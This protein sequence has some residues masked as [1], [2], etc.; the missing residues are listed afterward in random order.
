[1]RCNR[2][3]AYQ[4]MHEGAIALAEVQ[5]NGIRVDMAYLKEK[6]KST[7][8]QIKKIKAV[9]EECKE[10]RKWKKL[11]G[12][13]FNLDSND[14]LADILY[15]HLGYE[16]V[17]ETASGNA[18][19]DKKA[20]ERIDLPM[21]KQLLLLRKLQKARGTY[22]AGISRE[23]VDG[24]LYPFFNLHTVKTYR[25]S[26]NNPNFQ[27]MPI[28][29]PFMGELI[30]RAFI[31]RENRILLELD[32]SSIEVKIAACYHKDPTMLSYIKDPSKDMHRDMAAQCYK[33]P[34]EQVTKFIRYCGKNMYVFPEFYGSY[35]A[36][37]APDLWSAAQKEDN[38]LVDGTLLKEHLVAQGLG[39]YSRF[40][41]YIQKV[42][43]HFWNKRFR[44]YN[45]W[46]KKH[47]ASYLKKGYFDTL[48]GFR[49]QG[50]MKKNDV[51][52]YPVQG[53][54][55]H[56]LLWS[57]IQLNR[58]FRKKKMAT[59]IVGQ[60]HDSIVMDV[61]P[62][63]LSDVLAMAKQVMCSDLLQHWDWIIVP[64]DIEAEAA[65]VNGSW[66]E[67]KKVEIAA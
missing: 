33:L 1:M 5:S 13:E 10:V 62:K 34:Q 2:M 25:S 29:D 52:N 17:G 50:V 32:Y 65:P 24:F 46:R 30:R 28:R 56:C 7:A 19:V 36:Q 51:I 8:H 67:K 66:F 11:Y 22:L 60:I 48:T 38:K 59:C 31:P 49:C 42:E 39:S 47:Y 14:Q 26:S 40:E 53:A 4:L 45:N 55:F 9:L 43:D 16:A 35:Y 54:A 37:V 21:V 15:N 58:M 44:V 20:L 27:N 3:D 6:R 12:R 64:I 18:A 41:S 63:E 57:L 61:E 23:V